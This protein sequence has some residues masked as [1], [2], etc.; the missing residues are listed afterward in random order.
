MCPKDGILAI[1]AGAMFG[2]KKGYAGVKIY[3]NGTFIIDNYLPAGTQTYGVIPIE[4]L[5]LPVSAGDTLQLRVQSGTA[6]DVASGSTR[7]R[8]SA[9]Y[10]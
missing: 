9:F 10:I 4:M 1:S 8:I 6:N 2:T 5:M 7:T 3:K